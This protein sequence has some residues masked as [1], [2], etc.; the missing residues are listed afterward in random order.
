MKKLEQLVASQLSE[1]D[2]DFK[3]K[4]YLLAVS[5][6]SDSICL[7]HVY[8]N[9][10][11]NFE[12]AHCNFQLRGAESDGDEQFVKSLSKS[13]GTKDNY[14]QFNTKEISKSNKTSIQ[15]EAR[16]LRYNWFKDLARAKSFDYIVTAHHQDDLIETFFINSVRGS[17][18]RGLRSIPLVT[19]NI[20]RPLLKV[21]KETIKKYITDSEITYRDDSSNESLKY[22]RNYL[23]HKIIP[24]LEHVH[25]NAKKGITNTICNLIETEKYLQ[26]KLAEDFKNFVKEIGGGIEVEL[27]DGLSNFF[28]LDVISKY[29]FN[30]TQLN[31]VVNSKQVGRQFFSQTHLMFKKENVLTIVKKLESSQE[32]YLFDKYG[33]FET[34][35]QI[36]LVV[37]KTKSLEFK[38]NIAYL[39]ADKV[40]FPFVLRK[41]KA[42]D[43]FIPFGMKGKK[44]LSDYFIDIKLSRF[45]KEQIWILE[46]NGKICWIVGKRLDNRFKVTNKTTKIIKIVT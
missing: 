26:S 4:K 34:P 27:K 9:L 30:N 37:E 28:L 40:S 45:E 18:V 20:M 25:Q 1:I 43:D 24:E 38:P 33:S 32:E 8:D 12:I 13:L 22:S 17:G 36:E 35:I 7:M 23:R 29:G 14:I 39:D 31:N 44:K 16:A 42:G 19:E 11:L 15:E 41:W 2:K 6:G 10:N 21:S 46:N 5:G 3:S